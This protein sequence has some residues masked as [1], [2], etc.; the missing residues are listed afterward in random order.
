MKKIKLLILASILILSFILFT[1]CANNI[2]YGTWQ[3]TETI[4]ADTGEAQDPGM[5]ANMMVFTINK[6]G[7]VIFLDKVFGTYEKDGGEFTF[8]YT[9]DEGEEPKYESGGWEI[10]GTDLY[11]HDD[12]TPLIYHFVSVLQ[13]DD[14]E[15]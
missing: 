2:L 14:N 12:K 15:N 3:M 1:G 5:F 4:N 13:T 6:D 7:T 9:V 10:I 8:T 11:I